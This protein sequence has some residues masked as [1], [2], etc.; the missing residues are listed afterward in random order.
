M[1]L[2]KIAQKV[3]CFFKDCVSEASQRII[4]K[5]IKCERNDNIV[6]AAKSLIEANVKKEQILQLL[7]KNWN[8]RPKEAE[9]FYHSAERAFT[10][11]AKNRD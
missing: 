3:F 1:E 10:S 5:E 11:T 7:A 4:T 8:L 9:R 2:E 6:I